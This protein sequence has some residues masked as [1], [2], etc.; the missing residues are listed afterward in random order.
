M[1][2][3]AVVTVAFGKSTERL[4][5]TFLSFAEKNPG[6]PL[7]A[8]ILGEHL[9]ER[10]LPQITYHLVKPVPDFSHPLREVY[11]RRM[12]LIDQLDVDYALVVDSFDVLCLQPLP[13]FEQ[14]VGDAGLGA[15]TEHLG[16]RYIMGQ[17]YTANFL[18]C[19]VVFWNVPAS[20]E[21]RAEIVERGRTHFRTV[22]DDQFCLNE[23]VQTKYFERVRILPCQYNYRCHIAPVTQRTWATVPHL[24]GVLIYHNAT[25]MDAAK[26]LNP[27]PRAMLPSLARDAGPLTPREQFWK[28]ARNRFKPHIIK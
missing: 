24:D 19:G 8:F 28:R 22:A 13:S 15:I 2:R 18:N 3:S 4:D 27:N 1:K 25:C 9:P 12:S 14:L 21:I 23:V 10:Q 7:H 5:Y 20:R 6:V 16:S 26:Q 11:F 17:G